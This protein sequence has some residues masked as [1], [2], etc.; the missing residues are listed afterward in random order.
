[1]NHAPVTAAAPSPKPSRTY[2]VTPPATGWRT[3]SAANVIASGAERTSS[4]AQAT[5]DAGPAACAASA[6]TSSTPGP[7]R[8]PT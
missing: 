4:P 2:A 6:G 1:M 7:I 3:P 8:A 5:I